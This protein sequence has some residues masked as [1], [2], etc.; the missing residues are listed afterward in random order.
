MDQHQRAGK[1]PRKKRTAADDGAS[2]EAATHSGL[3]R[4]QVLRTLIGREAVRDVSQRHRWHAAEKALD[5]PKCQETP[6]RR[7]C[8]LAK[9]PDGTGFGTVWIG[10]ESGW[11]G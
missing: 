9:V 8:G 11:V 2:N 10:I 5:H 3:D 4:G 1:Y 7:A 6:K